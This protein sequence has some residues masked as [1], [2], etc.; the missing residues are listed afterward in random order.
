[1]NKANDYSLPDSDNPEWTTSD[2]KKAKPMKDFLKQHAA[3]QE[4]KQSKP[5]KHKKAA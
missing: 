3:K 5:T 2:F 4:T 1:M